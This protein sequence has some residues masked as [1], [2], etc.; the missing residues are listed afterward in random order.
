MDIFGSSF[1]HP[2]NQAQAQPPT[3]KLP[4]G[5]GALEQR[6]ERSRGGWEWWQWCLILPHGFC[7]P[8]WR[9]E[10]SC[11]GFVTAS[12]G[13]A[14]M[15]HGG[16]CMGHHVITWQCDSGLR[17][18]AMSQ[19]GHVTLLIGTEAMCTGAGCGLQTCQGL[20][21]LTWTL[22]ALVCASE[23]GECT[24]SGLASTEVSSSDVGAGMG[25]TRS[26]WVPVHIEFGEQWR[27]TWFARTWCSGVD[28][29]GGGGCTIE[30]GGGGG[31]SGDMG[32]VGLQSVGVGG[33]QTACEGVVGQKSLMLGTGPI[34]KSM[35]VTQSIHCRS[36]STGL[37]AALAVRDGVWLQARGATSSLSW[38]M[39]GLSSMWTGCGGMTGPSDDAGMG[40][41]P[42]V[43]NGGLLNTWRCLSML[44]SLW[45]Q[46]AHWPLRWPMLP[47]EKW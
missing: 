5:F 13:I 4:H 35:S 40:W 11:G 26:A 25:L 43:G 17:Q 46:L 10:K 20:Q 3:P 36:C 30:F 22:Q 19:C 14:W 8:E 33:V 31:I 44:D 32:A 6:D 1:A 29:Q 28:L 42:A 23:V 12:W 7:E 47:K 27:G 38:V 21:E 16:V 24:W 41:G 18:H 34:D 39:A 45:W 9:P 15:G 2:H 37:M